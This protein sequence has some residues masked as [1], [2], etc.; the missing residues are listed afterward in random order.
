MREGKTETE[1]GTARSE[2]PS[3]GLLTGRFEHALDPKKRL[4]LPATWW[5]SMG[6]PGYVYVM[7]D[8][9]NRCLTLS[10]PQE[11]EARMG[12]L[13][14]KALFD[15]VATRAL[16]T[17]GENSEQLLFDVQRR[18]RIG[19]RLLR[20]AEL[21]A[22]VVLIGAVNRIQLWAPEHCESL[23]EVDPEKLREACQL[24]GF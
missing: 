23:Q 20:Y 15:P 24:V 10:P 7:P 2:T 11:M 13:R 12:E 1:K 17:I 9:N 14:Q 3:Q 16:R 22:Q 21:T 6:R 5:H 4:T 8:A 18:L 19:D